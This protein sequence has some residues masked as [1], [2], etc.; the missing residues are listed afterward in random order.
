MNT[1]V[2]LP[3][4]SVRL[5]GW[6][7]DWREAQSPV[8]ALLFGQ[9][10]KRTW[11]VLEHYPSDLYHDA[12]WVRENVN[13]PTEFLF[14]ARLNGTDI[15]D[16]AQ[17]QE[18]ITGSEPRTLYHVALTVERGQWTATFTT[19]VKVTADGQVTPEPQPFPFS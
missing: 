17:V 18:R 2:R 14:M 4:E 9:L 3:Q 1:L 6:V 11:G 13:G 15:G 5:Y 7:E 16:L 10:V 19:L 12:Q 8:R